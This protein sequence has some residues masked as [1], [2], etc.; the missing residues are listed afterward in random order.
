MDNA[1]NATPCE[2]IAWAMETETRR[3]LLAN[4]LRRVAQTDLD[5][6]NSGTASFGGHAKTIAL[7]RAADLQAD[8]E[9]A[10]SGHEPETFCG[11]L[12]AADWAS[13]HAGLSANSRVTLFRRGGLFQ[14]IESAES[15]A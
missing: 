3:A 1:E 13:G 2:L 11:R 10:E 8:A 12:N 4:H 5:F 14:P 7:G 15:V 9:R 6:A